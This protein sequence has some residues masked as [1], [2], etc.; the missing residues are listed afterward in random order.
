ML[1]SSSGAS[2][3]SSTQIGAGLV[4][5]SAK[6]SAMAVSACSPPDSKRERL[7]PLARRL[8]EDFQPGFER[9][10]A[11]DQREVRLPAFEQAGEQAAEMAVDLPRTRRAAARGPRG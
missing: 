1:A 3:S 9:I 8:G 6:I 11:V 4:R 10:V 7:Q 2:T 5:N